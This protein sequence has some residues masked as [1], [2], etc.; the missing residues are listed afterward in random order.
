M[1]SKHSDSAS[2]LAKLV[3]AYAR[4]IDQFNHEHAIDVLNDLDSGEPSLA[5]GTGV[6]YAWEDGADVPSDMLA[7][8]G[9]WLGPEDGYALK[10]YQDFMSGKKVHAAA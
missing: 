3:K 1:E 9:K 7:E 5:L 10:A 6:F 8:T 4:L 2:S